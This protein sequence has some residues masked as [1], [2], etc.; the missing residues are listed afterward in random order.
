MSSN[1]KKK[2]KIK[3]RIK[4]LELINNPTR[5]RLTF[6]LLI[7]RK[8]SLSKLNFLLGRNKSTISHHLK[9]FDDLGLIK[10]TRK[11]VR[12]SI[13]AKIYELIPDFFKMI[14]LN[15][16]DLKT[17]RQKI[18][19]EFL[20]YAIQ[21]DREVFEM[22]K[23]I[24]ENA[25]LFYKGIDDI[26]ANPEDNFIREAYDFYLKNH[27]NYDIW[28]LTENGQK[29]YEKLI[30]KFKAQIEEI[31]IQDNMC[32]NDITRPYLI[33][34]AFFPIKEITEYDPKTKEFR[35]FFK[36]LS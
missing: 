35:A 23:I 16:E 1:N 36:A 8:L 29:S 22:I 10:T 14:M 28:F 27:I 11:K 19:K 30:K 17:F 31:I 9:K 25:R 26:N 33:L 34:H 3:H 32:D 21:K 24:F 7:F 4:V 2:D 12:G 18:T 20:H 15:F 5:F 6:L 13:K